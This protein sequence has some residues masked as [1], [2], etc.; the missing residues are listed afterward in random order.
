MADF[1]V[2][3]DGIKGESTDADHKEWI[4]VLSFNHGIT[5]P[6]SATKASAGG[7]TTA[8]AEHQDYSI[9]KYVD[10]ASPK[11]Y[12]ACSNGKHIKEVTIELMRASG[13]KRVKYMEV[14]LEE[15]VISHVSPGG[16]G[17][18]NDFPVEAVGFNYG[19]IK[20]IYSQQ[21]RAD[22]SQAGQTT[23]GWD[24]TQNK[25]HA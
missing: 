18:G 8:R 6:A 4:E 16:H 17:A 3:I 13:D 20:W 24:L 21:K 10:A 1:Y 12:E 14:K 19:K 5:Q 2:K 22:G 11:L 25:V 9:T 7:G 23:G 15:V